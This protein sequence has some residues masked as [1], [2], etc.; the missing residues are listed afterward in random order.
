M[1]RIPQCLTML[2]VM[3]LISIGQHVK[4]LAQDS[5]DPD[6]IAN[7]EKWMTGHLWGY[8]FG[9]YY[10][11]SHS[12]EW[13]RG[14]T[15]EYH[16]I[17]AGQN[18]FAVRRIYLGYDFKINK[19]FST[20]FLLAAEKRTV[21]ETL[22]VQ[23]K[24]FNLKWKNIWKGTDLIVGQA[25]TPTKDRNTKV[26]KYRSIERVALDYRGTRSSDLG[27][28]LK[29]TFD[30]NENI[31]YSFM[32]ANGTGLDAAHNRNP[33]IYGNLY[34]KLFDRQ[35]ILE[36]YADYNRFDTEDKIIQS[37]QVTRLFI[38]Y[39]KTSFSAGV[40]GFIRNAHGN[41]IGETFTGRSDTLDMRS[42]GL[43]L[44]LQGNLIKDKLS[45]Y[46]RWDFMNPYTLYKAT[47]Y[48][49]YVGRTAAY[50]PETTE[51][52]IILGLDYTPN[53]QVHFMPNVMYN[54]YQ[55]KN[56]ISQGTMAS[57]YDLTWR[58]TFYFTFGKD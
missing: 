39:K 57:D 1:N 19:T 28:M 38:G 3:L 7:E 22:P 52:M 24:F 56:A 20:Q 53:N 34:A 58:M 26:W 33:K 13:N 25:G 11:M 50:D 55:N 5:P 51:Q 42:M 10:Y 4:V 36:L 35:L 30:E 47:D 29:G 32:V 48:R 23:I 18:A 31:G 46:S 37:S 43:S 6:S 8:L 9:D 16:G 17:I 40:E 2:V 41:V 44:Y 27:L 54:N 45:F 21:E 14:E 49:E 15:S 12:D